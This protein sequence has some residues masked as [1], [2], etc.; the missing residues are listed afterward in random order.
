MR[1]RTIV[2]GLAVLAIITIAILQVSAA[3]IENPPAAR[4]PA[5]DNPATRVLAQRACFGCHSN[6]TRWPWYSRLPIASQLIRQH[7]LEGRRL[8]NFGA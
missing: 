6:E 5:W 7:V 4:E 3:G 8:G 1:V 2:L